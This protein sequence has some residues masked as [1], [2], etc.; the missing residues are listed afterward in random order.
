MPLHNNLAPDR[1]RLLGKQWLV[2]GV[3]LCVTVNLL[4]LDGVKQTL[5]RQRQQEHGPAEEAGGDPA[6]IGCPWLS[7]G[8]GRDQR[9]D[10]GRLRIATFNSFASMASSEGLV[11]TGSGAAALIPDCWAFSR[12]CAARTA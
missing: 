6:L 7:P 3:L 4:L 1:M 5:G 9:P 2:V 8:E 11:W 12:I 10:P